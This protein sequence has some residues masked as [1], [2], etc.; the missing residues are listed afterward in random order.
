MASTHVTFRVDIPLSQQ[1]K[2]IVTGSYLHRALLSV[3]KDADPFTPSACGRLV[4]VYVVSLDEVK[5]PNAV[6]QLI[7]LIKQNFNVKKFSRYNYYI[8]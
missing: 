5:N 2:S 4:N 3:A 1:F 6:N 7:N 8:S